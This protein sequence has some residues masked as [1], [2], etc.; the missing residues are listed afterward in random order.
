MRL[1]ALDALSIDGVR[2]S[3]TDLQVFREEGDEI[4]EG[5]L[6]ANGSWFRI[7]HG[8]L[9]LLGAPLASA[10][11]RAAFAAR[12]TLPS[13]PR[14]G[15]GTTTDL[16]RKGEQVEFFKEDAPRYDRDVSLRSF[17]VA[18]DRISYG[19]WIGSVSGRFICDIGSG[20][21]RLTI[22][23]AERGLTVVSI[24][25]SEEMLLIGR[26]RAAEAGLLAR[27]TFILGDAERLPLQSGVFD[28][29]TCYGA[30]HHVPDPAAVIAEAGRILRDGG[31]WMSYDP[32][33]STVRFIFDWTMRVRTLYQELANGNPLI[34]R[35]DVLR[36]CRNARIDPE[37]KLHFFLPPHLLNLMSA[38][39]AERWLRI[40][41]S[42]C[43]AV[44]LRSF[45]GVIVVS[46]T[47]RQECQ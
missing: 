33:R 34:S 22:P 38:D 16:T 45:A 15:Q 24:D 3:A 36:W 19:D 43:N 44:G 21:G 30:L 31:R 32:H 25:I 2:P 41:D 10:E 35:D 27:T 6:W 26:R 42:V 37:I 28:A 17:Y 20:S 29:A 5:A 18:S 13:A 46:G 14:P 12:H 11:R 4:V 1:A 39:A 9:D 8:V 23:M 47:K 7:E 40:S